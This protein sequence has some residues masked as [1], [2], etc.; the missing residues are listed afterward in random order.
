V[1]HRGLAHFYIFFFIK[2]VSENKRRIMEIHLF[3]SPCKKNIIFKIKP[4]KKKKPKILQRCPYNSIITNLKFQHKQAKI[5]SFFQKKSVYEKN[6]P[7]II[8]Y[9]GAYKISLKLLYS[10]SSKQTKKNTHTHTHTHFSCQGTSKT[11]F[12]CVHVPHVL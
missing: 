8:Y 12:L 4:L 10:R 2:K 1:S 9:L 7:I 3:I 6:R 11:R 5:Y